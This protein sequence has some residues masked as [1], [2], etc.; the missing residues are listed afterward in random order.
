[1]KNTDHNKK[2]LHGFCF[3]ESPHHQ[4]THPY[5]HTDIPKKKKKKKDRTGQDKTGQDRAPI[6]STHIFSQSIG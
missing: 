1:M 6:Y 5:Q 3:K 2:S 4:I